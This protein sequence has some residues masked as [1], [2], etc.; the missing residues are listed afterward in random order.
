MW[1][2]INETLQ[3]D[4]SWKWFGALAIV[5]AVMYAIVIFIAFAAMWLYER[6]DTVLDWFK[7]LKNKF[8]KKPKYYTPDMSEYEEE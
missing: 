3:G 7:N 6:V 8:K 5:L 4:L 1:K 2:K